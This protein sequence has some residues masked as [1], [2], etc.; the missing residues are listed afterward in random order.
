MSKYT[1][2]FD[3]EIKA[4]SEKDL[5]THTIESVRIDGLHRHWK[6][7]WPGYG[8]IMGF[9][10]VTWPGSLCYTGD[11]G[12]YLFQRTEDMV[13]FMRTASKSF[14]YAAEKCVAA[15][16]RG[17]GGG[18]VREFKPELFHEELNE[19]LN[20]SREEGDKES[21]A[22]VVKKIDDIKDAYRCNETPSDAIA[23]MYES[24]LWCEVP[25][26]QYFTLRFLWCMYAIQWFCANVK[27]A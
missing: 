17:N 22:P 25:D 1:D 5:A 15:G 10:I 8:G 6:C 3:A 20:E 16:T 24:E 18:D 7:R 23:A 13:A 4:R 12:D 21:F 9:D 27:E 14:G 11:M 2:K 26:C 19:R